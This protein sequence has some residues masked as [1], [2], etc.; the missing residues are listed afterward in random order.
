MTLRE[1]IKVY[2]QLGLQHQEIIAC[3][4][5]NHDISLSLRHLRRILAT[6]GLFRRKIYS[7]VNSIANFIEAQIRKH[8]HGFV[9]TQSTVRELLKILDPDGVAIRQRRRLRRRRY[10]NKGP[11]YLWH[12]DCYDKLKPFGICITGGIDGYSRYIIWLKAGPNTNNPAIIGYHFLEAVTTLLGC[13]QTL[14]A[15]MGTEN[16]LQLAVEAKRFDLEQ[17]GVHFPVLTVPDLSDSI[18][19][20]KNRRWPKTQLRG[21]PEI[22]TT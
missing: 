3:L 4:L 5:I 15:D 11:N 14:R 18:H 13:P 1:L 20:R 6:M 10:Y 21:F 17:N 8:G 16:A 19:F 9:V 7:D 22:N 2:Y 12:T